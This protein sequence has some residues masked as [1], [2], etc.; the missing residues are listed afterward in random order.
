MRTIDRRRRRRP[1]VVGAG[2]GRRRR[3]RRRRRHHVCSDG[4]DASADP[5]TL[6]TAVDGRIVRPDDAG[7]C[8]QRRPAAHRVAV[9]DGDRDAVRHRGRRP[10]HR[11]RR[12]VQLPGRGRGG[13]DRP[14]RVHPERR[15]DRRLRARPRRDVRTAGPHVAARGRRTRGVGGPGG[16]RRW[17]RPTPRSSSSGALT[18][19]VAEA[20]E[21]VASMESEI[22]RT[23]PSSVPTSE[24]PLT[25]L[26]RARSDVLQ[27][28]LDD[29]H[30][31][32]VL[33]AS[34]CATSPTARRAI[35]RLPAAERRV[36]HLRAI[37]T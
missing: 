26:P 14:L 30:R 15:S 21:L 35:R 32:G 8:G 36:H 5:S 16:D 23:S 31:R 4:I 27:R 3:R 10:G 20:A 28:R 33:A 18:G 11:R 6:A 29:V 24:V 25:L 2:C 17:T 12:P 37:R 1:A 22:W 34:G 19:H 9:A 7:R 13:A